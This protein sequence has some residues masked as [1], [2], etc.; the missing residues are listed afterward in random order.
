MA[1]IVFI[2]L[3]HRPGSHPVELL[4]GRRDAEDDPGQR[5]PGSGS[6]PA[7]KPDTEGDLEWWVE[8]NLEYSEKWPN[9]TIKGE[10][11]ED[12]KQYESETGKYKKYFTPKPGDG[13]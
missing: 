7:I 1:A 5:E 6:V 11:P 13:D 12:H 3:S 9:I 8:L 2:V 4:E 10:P